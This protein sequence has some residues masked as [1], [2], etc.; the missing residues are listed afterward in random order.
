MNAMYGD[1]FANVA[2][3]SCFVD[4]V[5]EFRCIRRVSQERFHDSTSRFPP[6]APAGCCSPASSVLS[7]RYD[8]L[9]F[10]PPPSVA[11][12]RRYL[13]S[14][15]SVRSPA[16]EC[17]AEAWSWSPG[18]SGR[19]AA[20]ETTGSPKFL[21]NLDCPFAHVPIRRRQD[22]LHQTIKYSSVAPGHRKAKAPTKGLS[23][24]NSMAF[25]LAVYA[26]Q[27]GLLQHHA[28][29]ASSCWSGSTGR[30]FHPQGS[31]ERFQICFLH[32]ILLSQAFLAQRMCP[33]RFR[34]LH[35]AS[36]R[37]AT[38]C[39]KTWLRKRLQ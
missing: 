35:F 9:P 25:G 36:R 39:A 30:A 28:R 3:R 37:G 4:T 16:D 17:A 13:G 20:E 11:V 23:T 2:I 24:L 12:V 10:I 5:V 32:L 1:C 21:G 7:R 14:T 26:S 15:R 29:L 22:C 8:F 19:D 6:L 34:K 38:H 18:V 31:D 33:M 27:C